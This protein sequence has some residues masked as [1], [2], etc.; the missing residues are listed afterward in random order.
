MDK[1]TEVLLPEDDSGIEVV[2]PPDEDE[3]IP[4]QQEN[5]GA[6]ADTVPGAVV[7]PG[8]KRPRY[9]ETVVRL[10]GENR[11]MSEAAQRLFEENQRLKNDIGNLSQSGMV[12]Y[13]R[14]LNAE[15]K[16]A[17]IQLEDAIKAEDAKA[18]AAAQG[19]VARIASELNDVKA[20][21][22]QNPTKTP[23]QQQQAPQQQQP[24]KLAEPVKNWI[25]SHSWFDERNEDY[26]E[27]MHFEAVEFARILEAR[28]IRQGKQAEI[29]TKPYFDKIDQH[30]VQE[31]PDQLGEDEEEE[32]PPARQTPPQPRVAPV[33]RQAPTTVN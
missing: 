8:K 9:K 17:Q 4:E 21:K 13:E 20:W 25:D 26:D 7:A 14:G 24:V 33:T 30:M 12:N 1:D 18:Q 29:N 5:K 6:A 3:E 2:L 10:K 32:T 28:L 19:E 11:Q 23:E 22:A 27:D 16:L 31:F 15:Q